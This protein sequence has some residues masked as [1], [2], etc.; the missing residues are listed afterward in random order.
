[1]C[2]AATHWARIERLCFA[3]GR[4]DAAAAGFDDELLYRELQLP[5]A[6]RTVPARQALRAEGQ[7]P[8]AAWAASPQRIPY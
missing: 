8:F 2:L 5:P 4:E 6:E 7:E 3:A 1:M